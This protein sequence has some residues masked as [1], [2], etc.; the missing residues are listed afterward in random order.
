MWS[1]NIA[2]FLSSPIF[3]LFYTTPM[4]SSSPI[5]SFSLLVPSTPCVNIVGMAPSISFQLECDIKLYFAF[6]RDSLFDPFIYSLCHHNSVA[7]DDEWEHVATLCS[8]SLIWFNY[9]ESVIC[10]EKL[11]HGLKSRIVLGGLAPLRII[12]RSTEFDR[13]Y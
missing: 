4:S 10:K 11:T 3:F 13:E 5:P 6:M 7:H 2:S 1:V 12:R 8:I 9:R